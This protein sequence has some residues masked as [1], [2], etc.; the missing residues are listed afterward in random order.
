MSELLG[1]TRMK[2]QTKSITWNRIL[3]DMDMYVGGILFGILVT[4]TF[5]NVLMRYIFRTPISWSE[6]MILILFA[7]ST[8][9]GIVTCFRYDK[10]MRITFIYDLFPKPI[11]KFLD[12]ATDI[13]LLVLFGF[14]SYLSVTMCAYAGVKKRW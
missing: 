3:K 8:Y 11:Q 12:I 6:E 10:H 14:L 7:W 4:L 1:G 5:V 2:K 13:A 9:L